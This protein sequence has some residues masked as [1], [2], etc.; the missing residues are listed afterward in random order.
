MQKS[1]VLL[2]ADS[3]PTRDALEIGLQRA[4]CS[5]ITAESAEIAV[6][7]AVVYLPEVVVITP[8]F[9]DGAEISICT[10]ILSRINSS[11][12]PVFVMAPDADDVESA[13]QARES[14]RRLVDL[15]RFTQGLA[16]LASSTNESQMTASHVH[17]QGLHMDREAFRASVSGRELQLT[18]TEFNILWRLARS[19]GSVLARRKLCDDCADD[20]EGVRCRSVDVHV[21]SLRKKLGDHAWLIETV[22]GVGYRINDRADVDRPVH[23]RDVASAASGT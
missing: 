23:E 16:A 11:N 15:N 22:R 6:Q 2:V 5:V 3:T 9:S 4:G 13:T 14:P 19:G 7:R 10:E 12:S 1:L 18:L 20:A 21:R 17:V 8:D